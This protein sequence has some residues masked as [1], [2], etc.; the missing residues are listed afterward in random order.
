MSI[1]INNYKNEL[2]TKEKMDYVNSD[3][4]ENMGGD[5]DLIKDFVYKRLLI[6]TKNGILTISEKA[7][8]AAALSMALE[9]RLDKYDR[10]Q[11]LEF[12]L[13]ELYGYPRIGSETEGAEEIKAKASN[14]RAAMANSKDMIK[15][16]KNS[17]KNK[18]DIPKIDNKI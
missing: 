11:T 18:T 17:S 1:F 15:Q 3:K 16:L 14:V 7:Y 6:L 5:S 10:N 12:I 9:S 8:L 13:I 4:V 2:K